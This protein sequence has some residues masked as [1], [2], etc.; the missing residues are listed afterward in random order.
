MDG[1]RAFKYYQ[2]VKLHFTTDKYDVFKTR[3]KIS[4]SR[5]AYE[6]RRDRGL[7]EKLGD[8]FHSDKE[9]IQYFVASFAYGGKN[10]VYDA[11]A[12]DLYWKWLRRKEA[13]TRMF[14]LD[15]HTIGSHAEVN[16]LSWDDLVCADD[17]PPLLTLWLSKRISVETL[18]IIEMLDPFLDSWDTFGGMWRD[19]IRTIKKLIGFLQPP[20]DRVQYLYRT[21]K[22]TLQEQHHG[23]HSTTIS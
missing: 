13:R 10:P 4:G 21:F 2:A 1:Y 7:F 23:T 8:K 20:S 17:C 22:E 5:T 11:E 19:H 3:G 14:E 9:L 12:D 15:L 18:C 6:K 16:N